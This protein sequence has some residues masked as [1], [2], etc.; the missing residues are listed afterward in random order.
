MKRRKTRT[1]IVGGV[2]IGSEHPVS[3]QSMTKVATSNVKAV[4]EQIHCLEKAKCELVRVAVKEIEDAKAISLIKKEINIP[5]IADIHFMAELAIE[6]I[7]GGADKIR[8]NPGNMNSDDLGSIIERAKER[9]VPIRIGVNSGSLSGMAKGQ[10]ESAGLMTEAVERYLDRFREQNFHNII[11]S[12]KSS[13]VVT[14]VEAYN[15]IANKCDYPL[16]LGITATGTVENGIVCSSVGI[17][18]LLLGG[19]G[20][21]IRVSLTGDPVLEVETAKRILASTGL[22]NFGPRI[23][24]CPTCGRCQ[25]DLIPKVKELQDKL[26]QLSIDSVPHVRHGKQTTND[27]LQPLVIAIMGCEVNG[28]GE[29]KIADCGVA[30]GKGRGAIFCQGEIVKTVDEKDAVR[31]LIGIIR[32]EYK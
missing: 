23:I 8:I 25:T 11:I 29:A 14:T 32:E 7:S 30:F 28:P 16:H 4:V 12:L 26:N 18:S 22:R 24:S 19:I 5:I 31:E 20:D 13:D 1:V 9:D 17:G 6:A 15:L 27:K 21:T 2:K 3:I 10:A